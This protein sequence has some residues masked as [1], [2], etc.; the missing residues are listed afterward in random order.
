MDFS[1]AFRYF[2]E[3][4]TWKR[5]FGVAAGI[6]GFSAALGIPGLV[7]MQ[8]SADPMGG[9]ALLYGGLFL[10]MIPSCIL[11]GYA[12]DISRNV[13][14]GQKHPLPNWSLW[15]Q[16]KQGATVSL[17][18]LAY[19]IPFGFVMGCMLVMAMIPLIIGL[20]SGSDMMTGFGAMTIIS[21]VLSTI[22]VTMLMS[23][24]TSALQVN[25]I[26]HG[27]LKSCFQFQN[28]KYIVANRWKSLFKIMLFVGLI[29]GVIGGISGGIGSISLT[30]QMAMSVIVALTLTPW[31]SF[32]SGHLYGQVATM[33]D[34]DK[35]AAADRQ[36]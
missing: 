34:L 2:K 31:L 3:D 28:I 4:E 32:V 21:G 7:M 23:F 17:G 36:S 25:Y 6:A 9:L 13:R 10:S 11:T 19:A 30:A 20:G 26:R 12:I 29:G 35:L 24:F 18:A 1:T 5:K 16:F 8:Q 15:H 22:A 14:D 33:V 27:T